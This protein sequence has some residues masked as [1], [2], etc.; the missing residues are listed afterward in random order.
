MSIWGKLSGAAAGLA[1]GG[2]IGALVGALAGHLIVDRGI[3]RPDD[4]DEKRRMAFT[5]GVIALSA[6]MAKAD[7]VVTADEV[8]AFK[9]VFQVPDSELK[10]VAR[11]FDLAR[12]DIRGYEAYAGQLSVLFKD[13]PAILEEVLDGLFH[14][15]KADGVLHNAEADY[16]ENV[17]RIFGFSPSDYQR[18]RARHVTD[19]ADPYVILGLKRDMTDDEIKTQYRRLVAENHPDRLIA[20]GLPEEFVALAN[21]KLAAI[22]A[23]YEQIEKE[24]GL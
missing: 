9:T 8:S 19:A 12:K 11:F 4:A 15:A 17:A 18:T 14:I 7:G 21:D 23:A 13:D 5:I 16:L 20:R 1:L 2:P 6:K 10:N 24:R 22:N 3:A